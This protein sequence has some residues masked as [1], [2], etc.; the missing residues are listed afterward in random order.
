MAKPVPSDYSTPTV[1]IEC[2]D[3]YHNDINTGIQR[4]VR[5]IIRHAEAATS[6]YGYAMVP[7]ILEGGRFIAADI[8]IVLREKSRKGNVDRVVSEQGKNFATVASPNIKINFRRRV[9][10]ALHPF[11][12]LGLRLIVQLIPFDA[13]RRF[14]EAPQHR[15]GLRRLLFLPIQFVRFGFARLAPDGR[16]IEYARRSNKDI[17]LL[18]DSSWN[19]PPWSAVR[20]F[21]KQGGWVAGVIYDLVPVTHPHTIIA[22]VGAAFASWLNEHLC[23]TDVFLCISKTIARQFSGYLS[24]A[25]QSQTVPAIGYFHLGSELDFVMPNDEVRP[26]VSDI[27]AASRHVF[28]IVGSIEPRKNHSFILDALDQFWDDGGDASLVVI[29]QRAWKTDA[30]LDRVKNH[31]KLDRQLY[32]LR[33]VTDPELDFAYRNASALVIASEIEG[34]GLP[35]VEAFQRGLPV[36]CS[37]IPVFRE[38]AQGK[39][40]FIVLDDPS[41]LTD[42]LLAFCRAKAPSER[43]HRSLQTWPTWRESTAQLFAAL[44]SEISQETH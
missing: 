30:F 27:F 5:N 1:F 16:D 34:F 28:I 37:D 13:A 15:W 18:L 2:T 31:H 23:V 29:G 41:N 40:S 24:S 20:R 25:M 9:R 32:L 21:K 39:A 10:N 35:I 12:H 38:I 7:V 33:D 17:L 19:S 44:M 11:W 3:T 42:A 6:D 26:V 8:S 22:E 14:V 36:L 4:V 43:R